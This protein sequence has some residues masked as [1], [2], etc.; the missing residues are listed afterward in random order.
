MLAILRVYSVGGRL[1]PVRE[2]QLYSSFWG[3]FLPGQSGRGQQR[4]GDLFC[5]PLFG[6]QIQL[7]Y[8]R[9][10]VHV[11]IRRTSASHHHSNP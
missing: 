1:G 2:R 9:A 7:D 5:F 10:C 3:P 8:L 4:D 11:L 6:A